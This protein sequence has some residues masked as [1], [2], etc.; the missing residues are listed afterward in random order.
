MSKEQQTAAGFFVDVGSSTIK[1]GCS[2]SN[3]PPIV[4]TIYY[5]NRNIIDVTQYMDNGPDEIK[6]VAGSD[7][8][9]IKTAIRE[10]TP[11]ELA[12][13]SIT[14][15]K[16][17]LYVWRHDRDGQLREMLI[18]DEPSLTTQLS[19]EEETLIRETLSLEKPIDQNNPLIKILALKHNPKLVSFL[20]GDGAQFDQL[21]FGTLTTFIRS[22]V[23][24]DSD[25]KVGKNYILAFGMNGCLESDVLYLV[26]QLGLSDQ[27][28]F[29]ADEVARVNQI[30]IREGDDF[31]VELDTLKACASDGLFP[32]GSII[33]GADS[34]GKVIDLNPETA[35][36]LWG[37]LDA[38]QVAR[39]ETLRTF[40]QANNWLRPLV[41][42]Q[43]QKRNLPAE[44]LIDEVL[45]TG[46]APKDWYFD[47]HGNHENGAIYTRNKGGK[48]IE[49]PESELKTEKYDH[50]R[51]SIIRAV[52]WGVA[53][54]ITELIPQ[55]RPDGNIYVYGGLVGEYP[56]G[57][58]VGWQRVIRSV[59]PRN[60]EVYL[61]RL[62]SAAVAM[63]IT[64]MQQTGQHID[65]S[66]IITVKPLSGSDDRKNG[67]GINKALPRHL[68]GHRQ[69]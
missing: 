25:Q 30:E 8:E 7:L 21:H 65:I 46:Y 52:A 19:L 68:L 50:Q 11:T 33:I 66:Q 49:V 9:Y 32:P 45:Q 42:D 13:L 37:R 63:W 23:T 58:N 1:V 38:K 39:Y 35:D 14:S 54:A 44:A 47:P 15:A 6:I 29:E 3:K 41:A 26:K 4:E 62:S 5:D 59:M 2:E 48:W 20:F 51:K 53:S 69:T 16:K 56:Y 55:R 40:G 17:P 18:L 61:V 36:G 28:Q 24:G 64:Y 67:S 12:E 43:A 22:V 31:R 57:E 27:L 60:R 34:V 10:K